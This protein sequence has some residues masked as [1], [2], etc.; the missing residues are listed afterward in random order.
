MRERLGP[1]LFDDVGIETARAL[2]ASPV[3][4]AVGSAHA[5]SKDTCERT[6][7]R[8]RSMRSGPSRWRCHAAHS[9]DRL[10]E[11]RHQLAA[12]DDDALTG[13]RR[14]GF[15]AQPANRFADLLGLDQAPLRV[16]R[17]EAR[18]RFLA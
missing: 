12:R 6:D 9:P 13:D 3:V 17:H 18:E 4:K 16:V 8:P 15:A 10:P 14:S 5:R 11:L 2:R 7:Q 1:M